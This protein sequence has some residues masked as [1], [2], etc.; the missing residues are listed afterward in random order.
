[1]I[2][3]GI[4][5]VVVCKSILV[6]QLLQKKI[7]DDDDDDDDDERFYIYIYIYNI[8]MLNIVQDV[9][10]A[11]GCLSVVLLYESIRYPV[12]VFCVTEP[13]TLTRVRNDRTMTLLWHTNIVSNTIE[14]RSNHLNIPVRYIG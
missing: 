1:M 6:L 8:Y 5:F 3:G 2:V 13:T 11:P 7:S 10:C 14:V 4:L 9:Q 12:V